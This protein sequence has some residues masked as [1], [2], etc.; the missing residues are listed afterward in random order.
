[1]TTPQTKMSYLA[2]FRYF[3]IFSARYDTLLALV[4]LLRLWFTNLTKRA[5]KA[6][7]LYVTDTGL[8]AYLTQWNIRFLT[9]D[10]LFFD[11]TENVGAAVQGP[12]VF[13]RNS[14]SLLCFD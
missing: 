12:F 6:P 14:F 1:M 2:V 8:A 11:K 3:N 5:I 4:Y 13:K 7:R 9:F 10:D